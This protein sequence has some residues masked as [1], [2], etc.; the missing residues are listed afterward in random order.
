MMKSIEKFYEDFSKL[1][2]GDEIKIVDEW[3]NLCDVNPDGEMEYLLGQTFKISDKPTESTVSKWVT[4][5]G[6]VGFR[7]VRKGNT[8]LNVPE[9]WF[10][11]AY[12]V[13]EIIFHE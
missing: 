11:N 9:T 10:I 7:I 12:S 3:N 4:F 6:D 5:D 1:K 8:N 2:S 13:D